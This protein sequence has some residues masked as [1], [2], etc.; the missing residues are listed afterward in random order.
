MENYKYLILGGGMVAGYAVQQFLEDGVD[1]KDIG[2]VS[3]DSVPPYERPPLSKGF[4]LGD[5]EESSVFINEPGSYAKHGIGVHLE[6]VVESIDTSARRLRS[7]KGEFGYEKLLIATGAH[8]IRLDLPGADNEGIFYL[9][10]L[11]D[12][13]RIK[14]V[15]QPVKAAVVVG[16]GF[17]GMEVASAFARKDTK[18]T[19]VYIEERLWQ[20]FMTPELS[21]YF[22]RYYEERGVHLAPKEEVA[23]F[24]GDGKLS[25]VRTKS[26]QQIAA[27]AAVLGVG[28]KPATE[29]LEGS[30]LKID[31]GIV[32]NGYLETGVP[33]VWAAGDVANYKDV[34]YDKQKRVEHWDNAVEQ[35]K[36]VAKNMAGGREQ[37]VHVPYFFSDVFDLS[38]EFWGDT[39]SATETIHRA[40]W[41]SDS[42]SAFW[43]DGNR[44][45][46]AFV[47]N[48]ADEERDLVQ[49]WIREGTDLSSIKSNLSNPERK[50]SNPA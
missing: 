39:E 13:K 21:E 1:G 30:G 3:S 47:M 6:T 34:I 29:F 10:S 20:A 38:Y 32:V 17:I 18:T 35:G 4:L 9:R 36:H 49:E 44:L 7:E 27:E 37:W 8:V 14:E 43:L 41:E 5:E 23:E 25:A 16:S 28:V 40:D 24:V 12:S 11:D 48:R 31:N 22:A 45:V 19:M 26:G 50:L 15:L 42:I 46:A 2:I 33:D